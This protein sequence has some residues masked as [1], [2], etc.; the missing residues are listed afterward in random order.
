MTDVTKER[1]SGKTCTKSNG[2]EIIWSGHLCEGANLT[3]IRDDNFCLWTRCGSADVP[4]GQAH[5]G[6]VR[7]V[8]C[9]ECRKVWDG[10][11][12]QFGMGA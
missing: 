4:A 11:H 1:L 6:D 7:E 3:P 8:D 5:E 2:K 12:G 9:P 10:E